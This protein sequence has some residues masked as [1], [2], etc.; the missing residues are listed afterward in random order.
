M[1][2]VIRLFWKEFRTQLP[3][4]TALLFGVVLIETIFV[5]LVR[6]STPDLFLGTAIVASAGFAAACASLLFAGDAEEGNADW[7]RQ[8]PMSPGELIIGKVGYGVCAVAG[9]AAATLVVASVALRFAR[10]EGVVRFYIPLGPAML[11][12][13]GCFLWGLFY[14]VLFRRPLF[15]MIAAALTALLLTGMCDTGYSGGQVALGLILAALALVDLGLILLW[16]RG[17]LWR[18]PVIRAERSSIGIQSWMSLPLKWLVTRGPL[19]ARGWTVLFWKELCGATW[20]VLALLPI[21]LL[22]QIC[23]RGHPFRIASL[24]SLCP[25]IV[26]L[27]VLSFREEQ[28]HSLMS[29]LSDRGVSAIH[30]WAA[31]T[32]IWFSAA[33]GITVFMLAIDA[34]LASTDFSLQ[35]N[36]SVALLPFGGL[37]FDP[38][39]FPPGD[40]PQQFESTVRFSSQVAALFVGLFMLGQVVSCWVRRTV[41]AASLACLGTVLF[42]IWVATIANKD[43]PLA[44]AVWPLLVA[45]VLAIW[46]T[47]RAWMEQWSGWKLR[48]R[49]VAWIVIPF[50]GCAGYAIASR[51]WQVPDTDPGFDWRAKAAAMDRFDKSWSVSWEHAVHGS[52]PGGRSAIQAQGQAAAAR[53]L[54]WEKAMKESPAGSPWEVQAREAATSLRSIDPL[55]TASWIGVSETSQFSITRAL[56]ELEASVSS[57][58]FRLKPT[59]EGIRAPRPFLKG[60]LTTISNALAGVRDLQMQASSWTDLAACLQTEGRLLAG[61]R[62]W[63]AL[64][65][66]DEALMNESLDVISDRVSATDRPAGLAADLAPAAREM[67]KRRYVI[68]RAFCTGEGRIG[69]AIWKQHKAD[70]GP[71]ARWFYS[72]LGAAERKRILR[73]LNWASVQELRMPFASLPELQTAENAPATWDIRQVDFARYAKTT[74]LLPPELADATRIISEGDTISSWQGFMLVVQQRRNL[75]AVAIALQRHRVLHGEFPVSLASVGDVLPSLPH[76]PFT[77]QPFLFQSRLADA[78]PSGADVISSVSPEQPV[79][80]SRVNSE[81]TNALFLMKVKERLLPQPQRVLVLP[82]NEDPVLANLDWPAP[83]VSEP[84]ELVSMEG[85]REGADGPGDGPLPSENR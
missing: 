32:V 39:W 34:L 80:W 21:L 55:M 62:A 60:H 66:Q 83:M 81:S 63:A 10:I 38:R 77:G 44:G 78:S 13:T 71:E 19:E 79:L 61:L 2:A 43:I 28:R 54:R 51:G 22:I 35:S 4:G 48:A 42:L 58:T 76:D 23:D 24:F 69:E 75:T 31:K 17:E 3:V 49:Q 1:D 37:L 11:S 25:T 33:I 16:H 84:L 72:S 5:V 50:L 65:E 59:S 57:N 18:T 30:V 15:V 40:G 45:L 82:T 14:S 7:L 20:V 52:L 56:K 9:F 73:L 26:V 36:A 53:S 68:L 64:P 27:G 47:R 70:A 46:A 85:M 12:I 8:L 41:L 74:S 29:F 6:T 67:L